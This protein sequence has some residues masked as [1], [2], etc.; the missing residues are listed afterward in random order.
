MKQ[1]QI[2]GIKNC[3]RF[4]LV[5]MS[6]AFCFVS[7]LRAQE[8]LPSASHENGNPALQPAESSLNILRDAYQKLSKG[9]LDTAMDM[10]NGVLKLEPLNKQAFL[11]RGL[12]Y[13]QKQQW[14][15]A[16]KDYDTILA[17]DPKNIIVKFDQAELNFMQK[18]Y[19]AARGGFVQV[20][21]DKDLGDF[22]TY[23]VLLCDLFG[24]HETEA[25]RDL[26]AIN[27]VGGN[28]SYYF[29]NAAWDLVHNKP[30]DAVTW[31]KSA[32]NI[33]ANAPLK[34]AKY[35]S[36]LKNLGYLPLHLSSTE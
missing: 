17:I 6:L 1:N 16:E 36:S 18:R 14:D 12:I 35:T 30:Q 9:E 21:G 5:G 28:P 4:I 20:E 10:V 19:D 29:G 23:K 13:A 31:L 7:A 2:C 26:N 15:K 24:G 33:Y 34:Y 8:L 3:V 27:Q 11:I 22:A 32:A 25:T